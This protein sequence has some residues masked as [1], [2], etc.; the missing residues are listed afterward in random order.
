MRVHSQESLAAKTFI[1]F[2]ALIMR[3]RIYCLLREQM[4]R[5][6]SKRNYLTVPAA[7]REL[8]KIEM[9]RAQDSRYRIDHALTRV[10]KN[11]LGSFGIDEEWVRK[12]AIKVGDYRSTLKRG[13]KKMPRRPSVPALEK[14]I[15]ETEMKLI[16]AKA[17]CERIG[18]QLN[19]LYK[20]RD[21]IQAEIIMEAFNKSGKTM[22]E[23][24]TFLKR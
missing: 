17:R 13:N 16:A 8:E 15:K 6:E 5:L 21:S 23:L 4:M 12:D 20:T 9:I 2:I 10:Q 1:G 18:Q 14:K 11:I 19:E 3:N 7:I 24:M 22:R